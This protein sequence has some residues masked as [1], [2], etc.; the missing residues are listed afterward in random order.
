M[1]NVNTRLS[2][3][4]TD[5]RLESTNAHILVFDEQLDV[6]AMLAIS[7]PVLDE[8]EAATPTRWRFP[9]TCHGAW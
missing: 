1:L 3:F 7:N 4:H 2:H 5:G 6:L 9:L 8:R